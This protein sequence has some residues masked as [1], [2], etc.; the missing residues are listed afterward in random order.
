MW[1]RISLAPKDIP[2][3]QHIIDRSLDKYSI[4][5]LAKTVGDAS[6]DIKIEK[7]LEEKKDFTSYLVSFQVQSPPGGE[8]SKK[9]TGLMDVPKKEGKYPVI[10]MIRGYVD[11][12]IFKSGV[13]TQRGGE[14]FA[15]NGYITIAPDFL[16][17]GES[18][19]ESF[20][21]FEA[22]FQ[23]YTTVITLLNSIKNIPNWDQ[24]HISIWA[25]SNGGQIALTVLEATGAT[26]PTVL[27]APVSKPFPYSILYYTDELSDNGKYIRGELAK[28][29]GTYD[30]DLYSIHK[31]YDRIRAPIQIHQ[32]TADESVPQKWSDELVKSLKENKVVTEYFVYP[33]SDHNMMPARAGE[34]AWNT[35]INRSL[36][37]FNSEIVK[38]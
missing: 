36:Q 28:F 20:S 26:Y 35:A 8:A 2:I 38:N 31:Y 29:E 33:G 12:E 37:F 6:S 1:G 14:V 25:H 18:D 4:E 7:T 10:V 24:K 11:K 9:V 23:T 34:P 5:N 27:W 22:R 17:Y 19:G 21:L 30:T 15:Q 3:V 16:G 32:G 13:G